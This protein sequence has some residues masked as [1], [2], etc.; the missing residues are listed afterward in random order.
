[1][2]LVQH[3][4]PGFVDGLAAWLNTA[5]SLPVRVAADGDPLEAGIVYLAPDDHHLCVPAPSRIAIAR[6]A[7]VAGFRP[8]ATVLFESVARAFGRSALAVILTGMGDDGVAGL[9]AIRQHG[10]RIVAQDE[11]TSVVFGMPGA[12]AA[13]GLADVTLPLGAI[14]PRLQQMVSR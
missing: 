8:S 5:A 7:P 13:A 14:A 10:G 9:R 12:A 11:E 1:V 6:S 3:I 4:A 2:L